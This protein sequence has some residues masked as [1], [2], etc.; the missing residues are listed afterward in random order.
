MLEGAAAGVEQEQKIAINKKIQLN[1]DYLNKR[2]CLGENNFDVILKELHIGGKKAVLLFV[3]G[4]TNNDLAAFILRTL[5]AVRREDIIPSTLEKLLLRVVPFIEVTPVNDMEEAIREAL[6][7]PMILFVEGERQALSIDTREY[8][9]RA[10]DEPD[11]EKV[12]RGSR[13]GFVETLM[14][15][16]ALIRRR[17]RDPQLRVEAIKAGRRSYTD[18]AVMYIEDIAHPAIIDQVRSKLGKI[19]IDALPMAEKTVKEFISRSFWNP[20]PEVRYTERPDVAA[21][22]LNEGHVIIIVDTSPAAIIVPVTLF[23]HLQ[24]AEEFR[25][26]PVIGTYMRWVRMIGILLS[27]VLIPVWLLL[28]MEPQYLP[29]WLEF[30]GPRDTDMAIPLF[31]QFVIAH[32]GL[33]LVRMASIHTPSP[34]ATALGLVGALLIGQIAVDVGFFAPEVLL[35]TGLVALG[36]FST[37][38]WE[39]SMA[40]RVILLFLIVI[41][42]LLRLPGM[43]L[44]YGLLLLLLLTTRSFGFPYLWPLLPLNFKALLAVVIRR[45][46]PIQLVRPSLLKTRDKDRTG[47]HRD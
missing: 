34:F 3:D 23:H 7:G 28:A 41:T 42:G 19:D 37:P 47:S 38:S 13:D 33:D 35:Y 8:P 4:L 27:F 2:L 17:I 43:L 18:I 30:V 45:P 21:A 24:H 32:F 1:I 14:F 15:N 16:I 12:T 6:A 5:L 39:L 9:V 29:G 26:D 36:I 25:H 20:F 22:H 10:P 40:N 31:L 46:I 11:I 44:G